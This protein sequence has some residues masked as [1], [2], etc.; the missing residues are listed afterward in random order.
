MA[1]QRSDRGARLKNAHHTT[2]TNVQRSAPI[3]PRAKPWN[4]GTTAFTPHRDSHCSTTATTPGHS[5]S[6]FRKAGSS[7]FLM[8][9][10]VS[11]LVIITT[12]VES[13]MDWRRVDAIALVCRP[14]KNPGH[15]G[16][17]ADLHLCRPG[18]SRYS[19]PRLCV[20]LAFT[21]P[22]TASSIYSESSRL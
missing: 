1:P 15:P 14:G 12:S 6:G 9:K 2:I 16:T 3:I 10:P 11:G 17:W 19:G 4:Q 22:E 13:R 5:L 8:F 18:P 20:K 21:K 7:A